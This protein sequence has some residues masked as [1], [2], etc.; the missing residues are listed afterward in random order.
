MK[1]HKE[2]G[3]P[4]WKSSDFGGRGVNICLIKVR[5]QEIPTP[6]SF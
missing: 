1:L 5:I 6:V 3:P 2:G 4:V